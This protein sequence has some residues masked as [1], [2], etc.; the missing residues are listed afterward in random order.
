MRTRTRTKSQPTRRAQLVADAVAVLCPWCAEPQPNPD[1]G[2]EQ[3]MIDDFRED[4]T[5]SEGVRLKSHKRTCTSCDGLMLVDAD[6]KV[7][8][9]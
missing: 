8:F 3:W 6:M 5:D 4:A 7:M 2:S 9:Q 1:D